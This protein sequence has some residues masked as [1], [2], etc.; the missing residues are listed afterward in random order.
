M[1]VTTAV[2][3]HSMLGMAYTAL[4]IGRPKNAGRIVPIS[5]KPPASWMKCSW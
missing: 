1:L 3:W 5:A 2:D 4:A